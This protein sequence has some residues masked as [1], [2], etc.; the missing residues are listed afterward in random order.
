LGV[1]FIAQ[2]YGNSC[3]F[4]LFTGGEVEKRYFI[5]NITDA[6]AR[7]NAALG[8]LLKKNAILNVTQVTTIS[9]FHFRGWKNKF[10]ALSQMG[11]AP[12]RM[13]NAP[14]LR[15]FKLLGS[16]GANGFSIRPNFGTYALLGVWDAEAD[17]DR[18]F[19]KHVVSVDARHFETVVEGMAQCVERGT[20]RIAQIPGIPVCGK[21][22]TSQNPH[23][24]DHSVFFAFAP[25]IDPKIAIAVYVENAG[26]GASYAAPIAS[27]MIEHFLNDTIA[28]DR[29][30]LEEKMAKA[31]LV[32]K[33]I[34]NKESAKIRAK[35]PAPSAPRNPL[36][37]ISAINSSALMLPAPQ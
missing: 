19:Q 9:I 23:G 35:A 21:T 2:M 26:W 33:Y 34:A 16:G 20:A 1:V 7:R 28:T 10:R 22:G 15:F 25:K 30:P 8:F 12:A 37:S 14:G 13:R 11:L 31:N 17:A 24:D 3:A 29:K 32:D 4:E 5:A 36:R 6:V 27:L 18:F